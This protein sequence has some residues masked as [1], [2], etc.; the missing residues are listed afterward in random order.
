MADMESLDVRS[1]VLYDGEDAV[2]VGFPTPISFLELLGTYMMCQ[3]VVAVARL[4]KNFQ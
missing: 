1:L 3:W 4:P 2:G